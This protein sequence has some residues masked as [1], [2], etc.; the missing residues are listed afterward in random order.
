MRRR[1]VTRMMRMTILSL[2]LLCAG[3]ETI[4]HHNTVYQYDAVEEDT[5]EYYNPI[6][7]I[8]LMKPN[9]CTTGH[10]G[11]MKPY[12]VR[13]KQCEEYE[14]GYCCSW[15]TEATS[16]YLCVEEWCYWSDTCDWDLNGWGEE[17]SLIDEKG[18]TK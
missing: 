10:Y 15:V 8:K 16:T 13:P 6:G 18:G 11:D 7:R 3:C 9:N 2:L 1:E 14:N 5:T 17:C 4:Y 12:N